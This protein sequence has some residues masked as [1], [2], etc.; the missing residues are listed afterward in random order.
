M[1]TEQFWEGDFGNE[2]LQRN[3]VDWKARVPFWESAIEYC[4]PA[5]VLE[6]GC[7]AGWNLMAM[8]KVD[9]SIELYGVDIN[10]QA[11]EEARQN[12]FEVMRTG[13][14]TIAGLYDPGSMDLVVTCGVLIHVAPEDLDPVMRAIVATS[15]K[16]VLAVEYAAEQEEDIEYRGHMGRLW[17]RPF[18]ALYQSLGLRLISEG[19]A[20]GFDDC[21]YWLLEKAQS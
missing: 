7:N 13:A 19:V 10:A 8:Q 15:A 4:A 17:R 6:V 1:K 9:P 14:V 16:Y 2:Y 11:V 21:T 3:R 12:G 20:G 5:S 18:G